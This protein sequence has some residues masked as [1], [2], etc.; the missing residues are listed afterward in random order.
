MPWVGRHHRRIEVWAPVGGNSGLL[1]S[2]CLLLLC[3]HIFV[4][5]IVKALR[6]VS[7][8]GFQLTVA[9]FCPTLRAR[10]MAEILRGPLGA[11]S[12][13]SVLGNGVRQVLWD[14]RAWTPFPFLGLRR[15]DVAGIKLRG[16]PFVAAGLLLRGPCPRAVLAVQQVCA[17]R[18]HVPPRRHRALTTARPAMPA[19]LQG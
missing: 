3:F 16:G 11:G 7:V 12:Q 19:P 14:T 10:E 4:I 5:K 8:Q 6:G 17:R 18:R 1:F 15:G 13:L 9:E 2:L